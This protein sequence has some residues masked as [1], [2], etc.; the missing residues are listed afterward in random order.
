MAIIGKSAEPDFVSPPKPWIA[1]SG[2]FQVV[3]HEL[4]LWKVLEDHPAFRDLREKWNAGDADDESAMKAVRARMEGVAALYSA[5]EDKIA[6]AKKRNPKLDLPLDP[7]PQEVC[8]LLGKSSAFTQTLQSWSSKLG[9]LPAGSRDA[10]AYLEATDVWRYYAWMQKN[11]RQGTAVANDDY[12][13]KIQAQREKTFAYCQA[14]NF[15]ALQKSLGASSQ[16]EL[17]QVLRCPG[18]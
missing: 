14:G 15:A 7:S 5:Q 9:D 6:E 17:G 18:Q 2:E 10:C 11:W 12:E 16:N 4:E 8:A 3:D 13:A 1:K